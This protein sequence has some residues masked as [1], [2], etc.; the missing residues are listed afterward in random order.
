[1]LSATRGVSHYNLFFDG[2]PSELCD[3]LIF[4]VCNKS[5]SVVLFKC[6]AWCAFY[7]GRIIITWTTKII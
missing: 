4:C 5:F 3:S 2:F 7:D 6:D 1:M